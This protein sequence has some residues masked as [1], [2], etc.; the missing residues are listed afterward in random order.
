MGCFVSMVGGLGPQEGAPSEGSR[1]AHGGFFTPH[2][3]T[4]SN[5]LEARIARYLKQA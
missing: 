4:R 1:L 2:G 3:G 5:T